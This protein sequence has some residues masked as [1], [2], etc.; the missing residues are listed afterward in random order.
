MSAKHQIVIIH[1][2]NESPATGWM[3]WLKNEVE[4]KGYACLVPVFLPQADSKL[5]D[6]CNVLDAQKLNFRST[7]FVAHARGAM[8]LLRWVNAL[9]SDT[10]IKKI[11]VVS[12]NYDYQPERQDDGGFYSRRLDYV[13]LQLKCSDYVVVH[14]ADD[15][16]VPVAAGRQLSDNLGAKFIRYNNAG[17]FGSDKLEAPELLEALDPF[18]F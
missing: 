16:Y 1:G 18:G 3:P 6:W 7:V 2:K 13:D 12:C 10:K 14:S 15:P 5:V 17:H 8:A 4:A 11:I 9:P